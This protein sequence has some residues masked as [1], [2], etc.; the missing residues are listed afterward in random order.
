MKTLIRCFFL[1]ALLLPLAGRPQQA[2]LPDS[3]LNRLTGRWVLTGTID[4]QKTVH[5]LEIQRVLQGQYVQIREVSREKDEKG[6]PQYEAIVYLCWEEAKKQYSCLWLDNTGNGGLSNGITGIAKHN[7]DTIAM[8]F[9]YSGTLQF[10]TTF[11]YYRGKDSWQWTMDEDNNG[12]MQPFARVALA[13]KTA[14]K[15][16]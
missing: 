14:T 13:R 9:K 5:D 2:T 3:L 6:K 10:H 16:K 12:K 1:L 4:G 7:G 15:I 8:I 11:R